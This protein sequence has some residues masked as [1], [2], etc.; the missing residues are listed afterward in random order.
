M[1]DNRPAAA[2]QRELAEAAR[3]S[4][5]AT[6][7]RALGDGIR[8]SAYATAQRRQLG[9]LFGPSAPG[10]VQRTIY[11]YVD[12]KWQVA[13]IGTRGKYKRPRNARKGAFFNNVTGVSGKSIDEVRGGLLDR[14][15]TTGSLEDMKELNVTWDTLSKK[16]KSEARKA[17]KNARPVAPLELGEFQMKYDSPNHTYVVISKPDVDNTAVMTTANYMAA[18]EA[19]QKNIRSV[20]GDWIKLWADIDRFDWKSVKWS[21]RSGNELDKDKRT[22]SKKSYLPTGVEGRP[23]ANSN[24][25]T[26]AKVKKAAANQKLRSFIRTWVRVVRKPKGKS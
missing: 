20:P 13:E 9:S 3:S 25:E 17:I 8:G 5:Q 22:G 10:V 7:Q 12:K 16:L 26:L 23:R 4:P 21:A 24:A 19:E 2:A 11:Q 6:A 18:W 14:M 1:A 15:L